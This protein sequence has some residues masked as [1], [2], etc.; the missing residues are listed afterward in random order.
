MTRAD[1]AVARLKFLVFKQDPSFYFALDPANYVNLLVRAAG[2]VEHM[3]CRLQLG[4]AG[5]SPD[6]RCS[7][8]ELGS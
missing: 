3:D 1:S 5:S 4:L 6:F 8:C 7:P 2:L